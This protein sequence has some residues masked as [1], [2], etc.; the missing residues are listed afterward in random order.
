MQSLDLQVLAPCHVCLAAVVLDLP[1]DQVSEET[2]RVLPLHEVLQ[3]ETI[4]D[5][6]C[7]GQVVR[8]A[9][10]VY[11]D[12]HWVENII[13]NLRCLSLLRLKD[14]NSPPKVALI[15][16]TDLIPLL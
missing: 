2:H 15:V 13:V 11:C 7:R 1:Q 12:G 14:E 16:R 4:L 10:R 6:G 8:I 3:H 9:L 5:S